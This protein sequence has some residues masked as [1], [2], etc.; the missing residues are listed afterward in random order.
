MNTGTS[1]SSKVKACLDTDLLAF[2]R[3]IERKPSTVYLRTHVF[4]KVWT[5]IF[6]RTEDTVF[7]LQ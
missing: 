7:S 4:K 5:R 2:P 6:P 3:G 1:I